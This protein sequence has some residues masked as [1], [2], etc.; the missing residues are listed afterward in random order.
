MSRALKGVLH[1]WST[2]HARAAGWAGTENLGPHEV[3][4][5]PHELMHATG[6]LAFLAALRAGASAVLLDSWSGETGLTR[7]AATAARV[8]TAAP[9]FYSDM[10]TAS[11]EPQHLPALR[12]LFCGTTPVP[13]QL[14]Q[15]VP[16]TFGITLRSTW[17]TTEVGI[18]TWSRVDDATDWATHSDGRPSTALELDLRSGNEAP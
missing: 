1:T 17:A 5:V 6:T 16:L 7:L 2:L 12:A 10:L 3:I 9:R 11:D 14:V 15:D 18:G 8:F 4:F 13:R